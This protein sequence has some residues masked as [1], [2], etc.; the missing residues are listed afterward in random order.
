MYPSSKLPDV[1]SE[2][3]IRKVG[4]IRSDLDSHVCTSP[5]LNS[6]N[7]VLD[8]GGSCS[9]S[10]ITFQPVTEEELRKAIV[11]SN[12]TT[13]SVDPIPT[14]LLLNSV[15]ILLPVLTDIV[16]ESLSLGRFPEVFKTAAV[17]PLLKKAS[18]DQNN[19]KNYR[20]VSN[21]SFLSKV[22]EKIV[23]QQLF[24]YL[25]SNK[26]LPESQSAYRPSHSTE[27]ALVKIMND[28]LLEMDRGNVSLLTLLDLSAA[29]DTI[30]HDI[31]LDRLHS[32]YGISGIALD[33]FKSY[34][35][36]RSQYVTVNECVS[37]TS[38]V[39]FGVPQGSVLGPVLFILYTKPLSSLI[40]SFSVCNQS[41]ADDTQL[42]HSCPPTQLPSTIET[43][44]DC[45]AAIKQWMTE[46]KLKL[47]D[48]K[49]EALLVK[50]SRCTALDP[51]LTSV[52]IGNADIPF[53]PCV[54]NL[55]FIVTAHELSLHNHVSNV[56]RSANLEIRRIS[57]IRQYLSVE[58][59]KTLVCAFVLSRLD[60][61]NALF[62]GCNKMFIQKLQL[63][64]NS[65]ARLVFRAKKRDHITPLLQA[66]H[67][68]PV[69]A[70]VDYKL[71][72]L[73]YNSF[74]GKAPTYISGLLTPYS[75]GR[76]GTR[77]ASDKRQ[78]KSFQND[79]KTASFG[80]RSFSYCAPKIWNTLP[81]EIRHKPSSAS[82]KSALKT[83][84][85]RQHFS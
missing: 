69:S 55:G 25:D 29:F 6:A 48:D 62:S 61:C 74:I 39:S 77:S 7:A 43:V 81:F 68:L 41:F 27:T 40:T 56:C 26:L 54:R 36:D 71:C 67:W 9:S 32:L 24:V 13:C 84:L 16:N 21:L 66:L 49:T 35:S 79:V 44:Q 42:H 85:F 50:S 63:V 12:V 70:R 78:L 4:D 5:Y 38:P 37:E 15:D 83:H 33:W 3:F 72:T 64:Q 52:K 59:T 23:Q 46:N 14:P 45:T 57:S 76:E 10:F 19:L 34:L 80:E 30:D 60:F 17:K 20:P 2:Y 31:L 75:C 47:N 28:L 58:A 18:L 11:S 53:V 82:F 22:V 73:C 51:S 65:A 1:F 8:A